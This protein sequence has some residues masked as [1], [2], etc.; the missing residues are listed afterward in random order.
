MSD[1][2]PPLLINQSKTSLVDCIQQGAVA[3]VKACDAGVASKFSKNGA[4]LGQVLNETGP[5]HE[6]VPLVPQSA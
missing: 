4:P 2:V 5:A 6:L 1:V 3:F